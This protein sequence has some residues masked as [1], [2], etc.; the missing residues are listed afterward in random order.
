MK[1]IKKLTPK[2]VPRNI[3]QKKIFTKGKRGQMKLS[4]GMIFS[5]ILIIIF[6]A[7]AFIAIKK[8]LDLGEMAQI[9]KFTDNLQND[10][11]RAWKGT[12]SSQEK[13]YFLSSKISYLCFVNYS[14]YPAGDRGRFRVFFS[15][16][17]PLHQE[18]ENLF[19]YPI[20][21]SEGLNSKEMKHVDLVKT[22]GRDNPYCIENKDGKIKITIEKQYGEAL[23]TLK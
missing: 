1:R 16:L 11:D 23:V 8:F 9:A 19:F 2:G 21:S 17:K 20:G 22:T 15:E 18:F 6:I 7:F 4:F 3:F 13:E 12:Q 10:I 5:I 14:N